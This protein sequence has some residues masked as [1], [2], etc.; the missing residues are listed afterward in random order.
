MRVT[1][2]CCSR[3][4]GLIW[5]HTKFLLVTLLNPSHRILGRRYEGPEVDLWSLGVILFALICGHLPFDDEDTRVLY[6]KIS[7]AS[8][9]MPAHVPTDCRDLIQRMICVDPKQRATLTEV[10][11]HRW[12]MEGFSAP[13]ESF[14]PP[15]PVLT[16][17]QLDADVLTRLETFG[18]AMKDIQSAFDTHAR[19]MKE[20]GGKALSSKIE[21]V[22]PTY[23][24]LV[25]MLKRE[26]ER[27]RV[28][29]ATIDAPKQPE[30]AAAVSPTSPAPRTAPTV[31]LKSKVIASAN[32]LSVE[33]R[34]PE[35]TTAIGA[36]QN[37]IAS[38]K[39]RAAKDAFASLP[40]GLN[41][42][43]T[44]PQPLSDDDEARQRSR[45]TNVAKNALSV[46]TDTTHARAHTTDASVDAASPTSSDEP[47]SPA[48]RM[49][50]Q[51]IKLWKRTTGSP[52]SP[53]SP[54]PTSPQLAA[55]Q[56]PLRSPPKT[57][58]SG[59]SEARTVSSWFMNVATTSSKS[60]AELRDMVVR[61][62]RSLEKSGVRY[63]QDR[64]AQWVVLCEVNVDAFLE[65]AKN[66]GLDGSTSMRSLNGTAEGTV[67]PFASPKKHASTSPLRNVSTGD[68]KGGQ[69]AQIHTHND[70]GSTDMTDELQ[71]MDME[72][73]ETDSVTGSVS[74]AV[75]QRTGMRSDM[76]TFQIEVCKVP[77]LNLHGL[78]F[79][80][81]A[82][83]VWSYKKV[84][85]RL[86]PLFSL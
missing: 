2:L 86:S 56:S 81:I 6:R 18:Y 41:M 32:E 57:P 83:G 4:V 76:V 12:T 78:H 73:D 26:R 16:A 49:S 51:I 13:P 74:S 25:E 35:A 68:T 71:D 54:G 61:V 69:A 38:V 64:H 39:T 22:I 82:G 19:Q 8:Y 55:P 15:R 47:Q 66:N 44:G 43:P 46:K 7:S 79:K 31:V 33:S 59:G 42:A 17:A 45:S 20:S 63:E 11:N 70:D 14:L 29:Q 40:G 10:M 75:A 77:R 34:V 24:L 9:V 85:T 21:P 84:Y 80:R 28:R 37:N 23:H 27:Q 36:S 3:D 67:S 53:P 30:G 72:E 65:Y 52:Q 50:A 1:I 60:P 62:L 58:T 5:A 48:R